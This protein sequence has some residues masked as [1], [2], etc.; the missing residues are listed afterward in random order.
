MTTDLIIGLAIGTGVGQIIAGLI[1]EWGWKE[2]MLKAITT[3]I[4]CFL[5]CLVFRI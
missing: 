5:L 2:I 3:A 1:L 4:I